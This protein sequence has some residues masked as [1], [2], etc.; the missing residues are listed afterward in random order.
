MSSLAHDAASES[1]SASAPALFDHEPE[2]IRRLHDK[3]AAAAEVLIRDSHASVKEDTLPE[4]HVDNSAFELVTTTRGAFEN[5]MPANRRWRLALPP[6]LIPPL[7]EDDDDSV[8]LLAMAKLGF[9]VGLAA[10]VAYVVTNM[11]QLPGSPMARDTTAVLSQLAQISTAQAGVQKNDVAPGPATAILAA[12][13][14]NIENVAQT[15]IEHVTAPAAPAIAEEPATPVEPARPPAATAASHAAA[16][17]T[18][19]P[20]PPSPPSHVTP[21]LPRDEVAAL[22]KR[23]RDLLAVGDIASAR[24]ILARLAE[25]GEADASLLLA[26]TFDPVQLARLHVL[27]VAPDLDKARQW[28][29]KAAEQRSSAA[30]RQLQQAASE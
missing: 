22:M 14:G 28:Y 3:V 16:D 12:A 27:G 15:S 18:P 29:A 19:P 4:P 26:G 6:A 17:V 7:P 10:G 30:G 9:A 11:V 25:H 13:Q 21:S 23:G 2:E 8:G 24:L 20:A 1:I 5:E